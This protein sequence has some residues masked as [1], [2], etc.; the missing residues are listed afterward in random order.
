[1]DPHAYPH[2]SC[3]PGQHLARG[4][5]GTQDFVQC[6]LATRV[7][8][9]MAYYHDCLQNSLQNSLGVQ[10]ALGYALAPLHAEG[11]FDWAHSHNP[12]QRGLG[13]HL[14]G[15]EGDTTQHRRAL[16]PLSRDLC[17]IADPCQA[18]WACQSAWQGRSPSHSHPDLGR[19][20]Y[21]FATIDLSGRTKAPNTDIA[22]HGAWGSPGSILQHLLAWSSP[23]HATEGSSTLRGPPPLLRG[24]G[25]AECMASC[26]VC[27]M[28]C[29]AAPVGG[30]S[31]PRVGCGHPHP[32]HRSGSPAT[33]RSSPWLQQLAASSSV[34]EKSSSTRAPR[35]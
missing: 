17:P 25:P 15:A 2:R 35:A 34:R 3:I 12:S 13:D 26:V 1:V 16:E 21:T 32:R 24:S 4:S 18:T 28:A 14:A 19:A 30:F 6:P 22:M 8:D 23:T 20:S 29:S 33:T 7:Q 11:H 9:C 27:H 10:R 5:F 31:H